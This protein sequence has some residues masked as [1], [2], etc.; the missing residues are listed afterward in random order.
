[1]QDI[2]SLLFIMYNQSIVL[3]PANL[4]SE[5]APSLTFLTSATLF[6][7]VY[8]A[9]SHYRRSSIDLPPS[10]PADPVIG[11]VRVMSSDYQWKTF[12]EWSKTLGECE[13]I[14]RGRSADLL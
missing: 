9:V 13:M 3:E 5:V 6:V 4:T 1:M 14:I 8:F 7:I 10:P 12:A 11:H 2:P